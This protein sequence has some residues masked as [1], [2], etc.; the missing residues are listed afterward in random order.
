MVQVSQDIIAIF[1]MNNASLLSMLVCKFPTAKASIF[2]LHFSLRDGIESN[3]EQEVMLTQTCRPIEG[4]ASLGQDENSK[5]HNIMRVTICIIFNKLT[6]VNRRFHHHLCRATCCCHR[7]CCCQYQL[8][9]LVLFPVLSPVLFSTVVA[10]CCCRPCCCRCCRCC[11][12]CCCRPCCFR[13]IAGV[14]S[15]RRHLSPSLSPC[16]FRCYRRCCFRRCCRPVRFHL[17]CCRHVV[18][19]VVRCCF[20]RCCRH[21]VSICVVACCNLCQNQCCCHHRCFLS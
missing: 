4:R 16:C 19:T 15:V 18:A 8:L 20:R 3:D 12:W 21:L 9:S 14:V 5:F 10:R 2:L 11:R 6:I 17:C 7:C 13:V 1:L